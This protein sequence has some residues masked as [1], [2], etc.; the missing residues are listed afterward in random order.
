M[1][2]LILLSSTAGLLLACG[3]MAE[4]PAVHQGEPPAVHQEVESKEAKTIA[5]AAT[6]TPCP[7]VPPES[8]H[9]GDG[10][11]SHN[12]YFIAE[13]LE[14]RPGSK[15][16]T[17]ETMRLEQEALQS[18]G[19]SVLKP[20]SANVVESEFSH[21]LG[22]VVQS[23]GGIGAAV[24]DTHGLKIGAAGL[25]LEAM[26]LPKARL[27]AIMQAGPDDASA[28]QRRGDILGYYRP[29]FDANG[30]AI[31]VSMLVIEQLPHCHSE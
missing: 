19:T 10:T 31:G 28:V 5:M 29:A 22:A 20:P 7:E 26:L 15:T 9:L 11:T 24:F 17:Q 30:K 3:K 12:Y 1:R 6:T 2:H 14:R 4:P 13:E 23:N 8:M 27:S 25:Q 16:L 18:S 21:L